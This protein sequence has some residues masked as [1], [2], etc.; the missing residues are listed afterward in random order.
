MDRLADFTGYPKTCGKCDGSRT[1]Y[2]SMSLHGSHT[3]RGH[4]LCIG[5][6]AINIIEGNERDPHKV[7]IDRPARPPAKRSKADEE[8]NELFRNALIN[9]VGNVGEQNM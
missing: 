2:V 4:P 9:F 7:W 6:D 1:H 8:A 3:G 5:R